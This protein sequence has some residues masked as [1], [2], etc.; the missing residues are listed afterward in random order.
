VDNIEG[1]LMRKHPE[2]VPHWKESK[3]LEAQANELLN[4]LNIGDLALKTDIVE[5][6]MLLIA[7][8]NAHFATLLTLATEKH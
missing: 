2:L 5:V 7:M 4:R 8:Q 3:K 1:Y 6:A